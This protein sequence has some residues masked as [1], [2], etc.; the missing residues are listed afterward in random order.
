MPQAKM[1]LRRAIPGD[2]EQMCELVNSAY[3]GEVSRQGWTTEADFLDGQRT[4]P[5]TLADL[6]NAPDNAFL[7]LFHGERLFGSVHLQK[8]V[9]F[10]YLGML[11][12]RPDSQGAGHGKILLAAAEAWVQKNW[13]LSRIR[14]SVIQKRQELIAWYQRRSYRVTEERAPFPYGDE[15]FGIPKVADL[16]FVI[17]ERD[18]PEAAPA[19]ESNQSR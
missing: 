7:L 3:R 16:E 1:T 9:G 11:T 5:R 19:S 2:V 18:L 17:L 4:D 15:R 8:K 13:G 10:A 6:L 14:M 12:I